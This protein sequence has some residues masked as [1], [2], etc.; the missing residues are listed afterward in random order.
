MADTY[1]TEDHT[2]TACAKK[3][4][5]EAVERSVTISNRIKKFQ[6]VLVTIDDGMLYISESGK[7]EREQLV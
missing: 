7:S 2:L 1:S 5:L 3:K 4:I 6:F